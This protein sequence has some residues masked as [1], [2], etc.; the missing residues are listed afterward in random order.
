[1]PYA[2]PPGWLWCRIGEI[3]DACDSAIVDGPFGQ[4][5]NVKNDYVGSGV[6][7]IRMTNVKAFTFHAEELRF[8]SNEKFA[9][10]KRHNVLP[11]D[12]LLGKVGSIGVCALYPNSMPEGM[13]ATTGLCRFRVGE[14]LLPKY[15][16][17]FLNSKADDLRAMASEAVQP[18]LNMKTINN[19]PFPLPSLAEQQRIVSKMDELMRL[20][21]AL[22]ARL[23]AAQTT[24]SQLLDATLHQILAP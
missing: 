13:L 2:V 23:T 7:V 9:E 12:V 1:M 24:A 14:I 8:I 17:I 22:E 15:L 6:P 16:C 20:C 3:G 11:N 10:L 4:A 18:F 5:I 19:I 21:D